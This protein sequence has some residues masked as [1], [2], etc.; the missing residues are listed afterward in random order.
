MSRF[1]QVTILTSLLA[2][3]LGGFVA[4]LSPAENTSLLAVTSQRSVGDSDLAVTEEPDDT[5]FRPLPA[6]L[7]VQ[8]DATISNQYLSTENPLQPSDYYGGK[9]TN[10]KAA[11]NEL[12]TMPALKVGDKYS[13]LGSKIIT[14]KSNK[15]YVRSDY[16]YFGSGVCW[17][18]SVFGYLMDRANVEFRKK[19]GVDMFVFPAGRSPHGHTYDTYRYINGG[20]GYTIFNSPD[21]KRRTDY[22]FQLNPKIA[23]IEQLSDL[24]VKIVMT[25]TSSNPKAYRG[26]SIGG[27]ILTNKNF[28]LHDYSGEN[29]GPLWERAVNG[30]L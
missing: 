17:T 8:T 26:Q 9:Y 6:V 7:G 11:A 1:Y 12:N 14:I 20:R 4:L 18:V 30:L 25:A 29:L 23:E 19:Y 2:L 21:P 5:E 28:L 15:G 13:V 27:Y 16:E 24:Q 10:A 3:F 22:T